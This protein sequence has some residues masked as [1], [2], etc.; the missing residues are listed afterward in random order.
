MQFPYIA[1]LRIRSQIVNSSLLMF[2]IHIFC[3]KERI[4]S[5]IS[6][7]KLIWSYS[8]KCIIMKIYIWNVILLEFVVFQKLLVLSWAFQGC[9]QY[10][11]LCSVLV[12]DE[13]QSFRFCIHNVWK[14]DIFSILPSSAN[15]SKTHLSI[16]TRI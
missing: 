15:Y 3:Q 10:Q 4:P 12:C 13:D 11:F 16:Q 14:F 6:D 5:F 2:L 8:S 9:C 7:W 1:Y